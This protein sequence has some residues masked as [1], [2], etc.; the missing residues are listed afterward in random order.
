MHGKKVNPL[1]LL[2]RGQYIEV[3]LLIDNLHAMDR[4]S[5]PMCMLRN[6]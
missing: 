6:H 5:T 4:E 1:L 2:L 3:Y